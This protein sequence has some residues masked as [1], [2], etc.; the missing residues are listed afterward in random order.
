VAVSLIYSKS[1]SYS[2]PKARPGKP[3][4][5]TL[6][7]TVKL[8]HEEGRVRRVAA[9]FVATAVERR[10]IA[11]SFDL[12]SPSLRRG[13]TRKQWAQGTIPVVPYPHGDLD[14]AAWTLRYSYKNRVGLLVGMFPKA[15]ARTPYEA[16]TIELTAVGAQPHRRWLVDSWEPAGIGIGQ[17]GSRGPQGTAL[18]PSRPQL[19]RVW[20]FVPVGVLLGLLI[21]IPAGLMLRGWLRV[22]RASRMYTAP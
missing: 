6:P 15:H 1:A 16:F 11:Q 13:F 7:K 20:I 9:Q 18:V 14:Y 17:P 5:P 22:R 19:S 4:I 3:S 21:L 12:T 8:G 2:L 10:N